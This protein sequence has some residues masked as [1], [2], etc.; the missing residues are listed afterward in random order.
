MVSARLPT[1]FIGG[2]WRRF[3]DTIAYDT[4]F[5]IMSKIHLHILCYLL[6]V[7][8]HDKSELIVNLQCY[9][10]NA[11][12]MRYMNIQI[13]FIAQWLGARYLSTKYEKDQ[14]LFSPNLHLQLFIKLSTPLSLLFQMI[15][16]YMNIVT[17]MNCIYNYRYDIYCYYIHF[18]I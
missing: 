11:N 14:L 2:K 16:F 7:V 3:Y 18:S 13:A 17:I 8:F 12:R 9:A 10:T 1:V 4:R 6:V 15:C 5:A